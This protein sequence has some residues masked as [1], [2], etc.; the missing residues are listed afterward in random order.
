LWPLAPPSCLLDLLTERRQLE[1]RRSGL[2]GDD[3]VAELNAILRDLEAELGKAERA[4]DKYQAFSLTSEALKDK[5]AKLRS[6]ESEQREWERTLAE[7]TGVFNVLGKNDK[8]VQKELNEAVKRLTLAAAAV[9]ESAPFACSLSEYTRKERRL[10]R[11]RVKVEDLK[12][13]KPVL[14]ARILADDLVGQDDVASA[15]E[16]MSQKQAAIERFEREREILTTI[17]TNI[18]K[19]REAAIAGLSGSMA[20]RM[21]TVLSEIT[22]AKYDRARVDGN[23]EMGVFSPDKGEFVDLG[24]GDEAFSTGARDLM[25]LA[26]RISLLETLTGDSK[27]PLIM[28]DSFSNF[29]SDRRERAFEMLEAIATNRQVLYFSCHGCPDHLKPI[30]LGV[31]PRT[32]RSKK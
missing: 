17:S 6:M 4:R 10:E 21:A 22:E 32:V 14:E 11:L 29:D 16:R 1:E 5:K 18:F 25:Y 28:D 27:T 19:A 7:A 8:V 9:R 24:F 31:K 13:R 30:E 26:A 20:K 2:L 23:L 12:A 15:E 3:N